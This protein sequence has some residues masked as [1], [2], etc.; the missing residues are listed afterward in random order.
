MAHRSLRGS[1][2]RDP[3]GRGSAGGRLRAAFL[4]VT[5]A[6]LAGSATAQVELA[7]AGGAT[8]SPASAA[9]PSGRASAPP[10]EHERAR[11]G[12]GGPDLGEA[13]SPALRFRVAEAYR[14]A[15]TAVRT[16]PACDALFFRL[17][18]AGEEKLAATLYR[19]GGDVGACLRPVPAF[20]CVGCRQTVVC[21]SFSRLSCAGGAAILIH[22]ALH[23]A[24]LPERPVQPGAMSAAEITAIVRR[25]C[26]L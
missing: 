12:A 19:G 3:P 8:A 16:R 5:I 14:L 22:E 23:F 4:G 13:V 9:A 24:G 2:R 10:A 25:S 26:S 18:A 6:V 11:A 21:P 20:T 15:V 1:F 17:G 7:D